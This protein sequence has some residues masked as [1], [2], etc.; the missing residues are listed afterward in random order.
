MYY[1][2]RCTPNTKCILGVYYKFRCKLNTN[3]IQVYSTYLL[4]AIFFQLT[5]KRLCG[6][7]FLWGWLRAN[8][9]GTQSNTI[10]WVHLTSFL[11]NLSPRF[12]AKRICRCGSWEQWLETVPRHGTKS[13]EIAQVRCSECWQSREKSINCGAECDSRGSITHRIK[14]RLVSHIWLWLHRQSWEMVTICTSDDSRERSE[15][16]WNTDKH[17]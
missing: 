11:M 5:I 16:E 10:L 9:H 15:A 2:L 17:L 12:A 7:S 4:V 8:K 6:C 13:D 1:I 14:N 3:I